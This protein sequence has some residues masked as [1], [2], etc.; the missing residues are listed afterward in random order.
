M[1]DSGYEQDFPDRWSKPVAHGHDGDG[2]PYPDGWRVF[3]E[4]ASSGLW[5][6]AAD[7]AAVSVEIVRA[8]RGEPTAFLDPGLARELVTPVAGEYGLGT[9]VID[10]PG[11]RWFGH[12]GDKY[13]Y[14]CFTATDLHSGVGLVVLANLGGDSPLIAD[15]LNELGG[16]IRY[17]AG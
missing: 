6:S 11:V 9:C 1:R 17:L 12:P 7:L 4:M 2:N 14:Q 10:G 15:V 8:V 13:S 3:P 16:H 5:C